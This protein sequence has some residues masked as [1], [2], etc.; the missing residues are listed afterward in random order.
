MTYYGRWTYKYEIATQKGAA[1]V[2]IVHETAPA[3]YGYN[4]VRSSNSHE[5]VRRRVARRRDSAW[6]SK[7]GSRSPRRA[8]LFAAGGAE[9]R[10]A[11]RRRDD[12]GIQAGGAR[13][14]RRTSTSRSTARTIQSN[15]VVAKIDGSDKKDE[16]V[17]LHRA[18]GSSRPRHDRSKATRSTTAQS[19][20][21]RASSC[22]AGDREGV[23]EVAYAAQAVDSVSLR[24]R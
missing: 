13:T 8:E 23:H 16:Y 4:V 3:A 7:A 2:F 18:L 19:T 21:Q 1:A 22:H 10:H 9:L 11:A 17:D 15:N 12:E 20:T 5:A 14:R 24:H 6:A